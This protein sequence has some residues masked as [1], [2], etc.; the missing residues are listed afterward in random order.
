MKKLTLP[1]FLLVTA[2]CFGQ[3]QRLT[4]FETTGLKS[5]TLTLSQNKLFFEATD[6]ENGNGLFFYD[7]A[8]ESITF[9][10]DINPSGEDGLVSVIP[11]DNGIVFRATDGVNGA[12]LWFSD[13]TDAGTYM[14]KD[15]NTGGGSFPEQMIAFN[16]LVLFMANDGTNG[17]EMWKSDGTD[18]GTQ[19]LLNIAPGSADGT[20]ANTDIV[21]GKNNDYV[22]FRANN[23]SQGFELYISDGTTAGTRQVQDLFAGGG[24]GMGETTAEHAAIFNGTLFFRGHDGG[25]ATGKELRYFDTGDETIKLVKEINPGANQ[26]ADIKNLFVVGNKLFFRAKQ[27]NEGV[28]PYITDGTEAGTEKIADLRSNGGSNPVYQLGDPAT[29]RIFFRAN[30]GAGNEPWVS[31]GTAIGTNQIID[32]IT[33][34]AS[35][36]NFLGFLDGYAYFNANT[37]DTSPFG[38]VGNELFA[39]DGTN[40]FLVEDLVPGST[41]STVNTN[42]VVTNGKLYFTA[43]QNLYVLEPAQFVNTTSVDD[44]TGIAVGT[45]SAPNSFQL[46]LSGLTQSITITPPDGF[47]V[48]LNESDGF[49]SAAFPLEPDASGTID[50]TI[51]VRF[52]PVLTV[53]YEDSV[54]IEGDDIFTGR[55]Q[56]T[57]EGLAPQPQGLL[58]FD[59]FSDPGLPNGWS[60]GPETTGF[61]TVVD[62][63]LNIAYDPAVQQRATAIRTFTETSGVV[64]FGF[65]FN[66]DRQTMNAPVSIKN[67]IGDVV[68]RI[69][70]ENG[71]ELV[72]GLD[73][74]GNPTSTVVFTDRNAIVPK[75]FDHLVLLKIDTDNNTMGLS[76][77]GVEKPEGQDV[78]L[79]NLTS[80]VASLEVF[81][82]YLFDVGRIQM[83]DVIIGSVNKWDLRRLLLEASELAVSAEVGSNPGEYPQAAVDTFFNAISMA[84]S[85]FIDGI[86]QEVIDQGLV[87]LSNAITTFRDSI[88][89]SLAT[90]TIDPNKRHGLKDG[91]FGYNNRSVDQA[92]SYKNPEF[93]DALKAGKT[94]WMR[95]L[96]G[97][98]SDP[99]NMNTGEYELEWIEQFRRVN[100]QV[101]AYE[102]VEVKGPQLVYDL[103]QALGEAGA[104]LIVTWPGFMAGPEE[105][106][107][108]AKFCEDNNIVV[109]YWQLNNEPYFFLP[110]RNHWFYNNGADYAAKMEALDQAIKEGYSGALTAPNADWGVDFSGNFSLGVR[111]FNPQ[112]YDVLS[113]HSYASFNNSN[114]APDL[115]IRNANAGMKIGGTDAPTKA[116]NVYGEDFRYFITEFNVFNNGFDKSY[117]AGMYNAEFMIR[118]TVFDN[119]D[120]LGLHVFNVDVV[121]P[122]FN[123][124]SLLDNAFASGTDVDADA[125]EYGFNIS[126]QGEVILIAGEALNNSNFSLDTEVTGGE[127]VAAEHPNSLVSE[128]PALFARAYNGANNKDYVLISNKSSIPHEITLQGMDLPQDV[129]VTSITSDDP[130]VLSGILPTQETKDLSNGKITVPGYSMTRLEWVVGQRTPKT[131]R[132]FKSEVTSSG[133]HLKW[134]EDDQA[135][136]YRIKMGHNQNSLNQVIEITG[137]ENNEYLL[138]LSYG[139]QTNIAVTAFNSV[140][141]SAI[142]NIIKVKYER[143]QKPK[144]VR[145]RPKDGR[146]TLLWESVANANGYKV[147]YGTDRNQLTEEVEASNTS[148][149]N[150]KGLQNGQKY[151]FSVRAYSGAGISDQSRILSATPQATLPFAPYDLRGGEDSNGTVNLT[152]D[153]TAFTNGG[154]FNLYRS[155]EPWDGYQLVAEG[156]VGTTYSDGSAM[157]VGTYYYIVKAE[158]S[159]GESFYPS[160]ILTVVKTE[161]SNGGTTALT[162]QLNLEDQKLLQ[163]QIVLRRNPVVNQIDLAIPNTVEV[164][165]YRVYDVQGKIVKTGRKLRKRTEMQISLRTRL[166]GLYFLELD[167]NVGKQ[168]IKI[169]NQ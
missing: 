54:L 18:A 31:D 65:I 163:H 99:F 125:I 78:P 112:Y 120:Y 7:L 84:T 59:T 10:K 105:A 111:N 76:V 87:D 51:Y 38:N 104:K 67:S 11:F 91:L 21:Y 121:V 95:Y 128:I 15:I 80:N 23:G 146:V 48:S 75:D 122:N 151:F 130:L 60:E 154:T 89:K 140:G 16:G 33:N 73:S 115:A 69:D 29:G 40:V 97:T 123:H 68:A 1:L 93:V 63:R 166:K 2:F 126:T 52:A 148:G 22:F 37:N 43:Q 35:N 34:G 66:T 3:I 8:T 161:S 164:N 113:Y 32:L 133:L 129:L 168:T 108:F 79:L 82:P 98:I 6:S 13:G 17:K 20:P 77:N 74:E 45:I 155:S 86:A 41:G 169:I 152:W 117:Y 92:W 49:T 137:S 25:A 96:S 136:G 44:F 27:G 109:E 114:P 119:M 56:V 62:D 165:G 143:P 53:T 36:P 58:A 26:Q 101:K 156:I 70:F 142:S 139:K 47:Q 103:Y 28:E 157:E 100:N 46:Q 116:R 71:I 167:T 42:T 24:S 4:N 153:E 141:E 159:L 110:N 94:G 150:L 61:V 138:P 147:Y 14:I 149:F 90:I 106:R 83:D 131:N 39:T 145:V 124:N 64:Y 160:N 19:L 88:V 127:V 118:N 5:S 132:I 158:N 85:V 30:G 81:V 9:V 57:G 72:T 107:I 144:L 55:V 135:D 102:R 134:W 12:E 162:T 50:R